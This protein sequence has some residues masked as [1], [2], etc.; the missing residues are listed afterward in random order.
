MTVTKLNE[1]QIEA[2]RTR[3]PQ[4]EE[5]FIEMT[6]E[7]GKELLEQFKEDLEEVQSN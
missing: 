5:T 7:S 1:E 4:V 3:A 2:F 6:G